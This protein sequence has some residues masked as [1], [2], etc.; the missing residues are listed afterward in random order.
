MVNLKDIIMD[1]YTD[2][3][4]IKDTE[5]SSLGKAVYN[6]SM[7]GN[8]AL[9][10]K[11]LNEFLDKCRGDLSHKYFNFDIEVQKNIYGSKT[12]VPKLLVHTKVVDIKDI[13]RALYL[14]R[15]YFNISGGLRLTD[16]PYYIKERDDSIGYFETGSNDLTLVLDFV[17]YKCNEIY[18]DSLLKLK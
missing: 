7:E 11:L 15:N 17:E 5:I 4:R 9:R 8:T 18:R 3:I 13:A 12:Y 16:A 6:A 14:L 1:K 10:D 2:S